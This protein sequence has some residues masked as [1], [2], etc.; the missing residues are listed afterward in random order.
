M[1]GLVVKHYAPALLV[2]LLALLAIVLLEGKLVAVMALL[3]VVGSWFFCALREVEARNSDENM[4]S[5]VFSEGVQAELEVI[6]TQIEKI[7]NEETEHVS[8]HIKRIGSLIEDST[9]RLQQSFSN[10]VTKTN[11]QTE[12]AMKLVNRI[13]GDTENN[14]NSGLLIS[15]FIAK[16][17]AIIQHYVDLLVQI[18][19]RSIGAIHRI[20]DMTHYMEG[21]FSILDNVQKLADQTNLL[22]LNA[23]I[24]A[25][26]AGEVGRGFA[27]VADEVRAL[28][29]TSSSLNEQIR[30]TIGQVKGR[31]REV[32][33]EVGAIAS[34]DMNTAI[35]GKINI[36]RMLGQVEEINIDTNT[37]LQQLAT[38]SD[39][40]NQEINHS[41]Q[42]LQFEDI[43]NQLAGHIQ[44][45]LEHIHEVAIVSHTEVASAC[46]EHEL[47]QVA[48]KL[49]T[50]RDRFHAQNIAQKVVQ[51]SMQEGDIDLF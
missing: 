34:L 49:N 18:S 12:M 42:A 13:A 1:T 47:K 40:I 5:S 3:L 14:D 29:I 6:G 32:S 22:A 35:E 8:E 23:A 44:E 41:I 4:A 43:V 30:E 16:T 19:D 45:R 15:D 51:R 26:R 2:S 28:S 33:D 24:E 7:L 39:A 50:L 46:D 38:S 10:V 20:D 48:D 11:L 21:M 37:I 31:M 9:L 36:D 27:V 25:A 17:G